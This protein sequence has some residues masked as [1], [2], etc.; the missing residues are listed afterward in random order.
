MP[1][2]KEDYRCVATSRT[3]FVQQVVANY[4]CRG[5]YFFAQGA[6]PTGKDPEL[7]DQKLLDRYDIRQT[8]KTRYRRKR[9]GEANLQYIRFKSSWLMLA[10]HGKHDWFEE[11]SGNIRDCR[12]VPI[13]FEGYSI[14]LRQGLYRPHRLKVVRDGPPERDDKMRVRVLIGRKTLRDLRAEFLELATRRPAGV[15]A[16]K[17]WNL[18]YEP[19]A[20][21]RQ[22]KLTLLRQVNKRRKRAGL[23]EISTKCL[24]MRRIIVKP[25]EVTEEPVME[26]VRNKIELGER[27]V[28]AA[29]ATGV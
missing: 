11:E 16:A 10:T 18:P 8:C 22:Q 25:F 9:K 27:K 5:Y 21:I 19:Y 4:V 6:I 1:E 7:I 2:R 13:H 3:G 15:L 23:I 17:F 12:E 29:T 14:R 26:T 20:P 24:R 28:P